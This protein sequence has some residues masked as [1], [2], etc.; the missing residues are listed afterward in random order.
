M[1]LPVDTGL[2]YLVSI[3]STPEFS[4]SLVLALLRL[5]PPA[6][7]RLDHLTTP[8]HSCCTAFSG[9]PGLTIFPVLEVVPGPSSFQL[10]AVLIIK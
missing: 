7:C 5:Q 2:G 10:P 9:Q 8:T 6:C 3:A 1:N 4:I